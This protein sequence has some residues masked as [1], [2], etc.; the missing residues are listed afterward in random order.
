MQH[1]F[2]LANCLRNNLQQQKHL[3]IFHRLQHDI[4]LKLEWN[5]AHNL[6]NEKASVTEKN[7]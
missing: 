6:C 5:D 4:Q 2:F 7:L 1:G 3:A